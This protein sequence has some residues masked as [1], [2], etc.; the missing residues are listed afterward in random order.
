MFPLSLSLSS[1]PTLISSPPPPPSHSSKMSGSRTAERNMNE[2]RYLPLSLVSKYYLTATYRHIIKKGAKP[3]GS[4]SN[5]L[6]TGRRGRREGHSVSLAPS[7]PPPP[8][9]LSAYMPRGAVSH[10]FRW[11]RSSV[12]SFPALSRSCMEP[13]VREAWRALSFG[14]YL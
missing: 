5:R 7:P 1:F 4:Q 2:I 14:P 8:P 10:R 11:P 6:K 9:S 13:Q 3:A 12:S